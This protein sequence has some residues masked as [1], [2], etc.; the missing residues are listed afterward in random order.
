MSEE[1]RNAG[2]MSERRGTGDMGHADDM[3]HAGDMGHASDMSERR[4]TG[5][6][7]DAHDMSG[8]CG[9]A[10][11]SD[12]GDMADMGEARDTG[13]MS[14]RRDTG[15]MGHAGDMSGPCGA[16]RASDAGDMSESLPRIAISSRRSLIHIGSLDSFDITEGGKAAARCLLDYLE[17][18]GPELLRRASDIYDGIIPNENFGGEY[19]A[20]QWICRLLLAPEAARREFLSH[21]EAASWHEY[22][23]EGD[24]AKLREYIGRKYHFAELPEGDGGAARR[25]L[26]FLEDF[27]LFANPDRNRWE[28]TAKNLSRIG[29]REGDAIA[30]V[31]AGPGYFSFKF[32]DMAGG[33][34]KVYAIETN[35]M[36]LDYLHKYIGRHG[37]GNVE[38]VECGTEGIGLA[39][40]AKVDKVFMCSLYHVLYAALTEAE[41]ATYIGSIEAALAPGGRLIVVDNDLVEDGELP[42]HGP[43]I[44]KDLIV[45][46]LW[47]YGFALR[48]SFRFT[49]QRY[50]LI[51]GR[52]GEG[53]NMAGADTCGD[54]GSGEPLRGAGEAAPSAT[55][56]GG[57]LLRGAGEAAPSAT[58]DGG[59]LL[60]GA[61]E[62][63]PS[64]CAAQ[65]A[66]GGGNSTRGDT[67]AA[68]AAASAGGDPLRGDGGEPNIAGGGG[69]TIAVRSRASLVNYRIADA[70]PT[71]GFTPGGR[72]A[73]ALFLDALEAMD[74]HLIQSAL[75][76]YR[77]LI[78]RERA[79]DEYTAFEWICLCLL[80]GEG[81]R[82]EML[83]DDLA[84]MY[85]DLLAGRD[86][87]VLRKYLKTK[88]ELPGYE[89]D[90]LPDLGKI[91]E[92]IAF[93]NPNRDSWERTEEMLKFIG[94]R[95]GQSVAD[96]GCG[97]GYFTYR[98]AR[99][100]GGDRGGRSDGDGSGR[101]G[102]SRDGNGSGN[103]GNSD[104]N[105]SG[106]G[107]VYATE[108]NREA[109]SYVEDIRERFSLPIRPI[110][111]RLDD[112]CLPEACAD[113]VFMCSMYHAVYIASIE[114]VKDAFV[115]SVKKALRP[116]GRLI[117]VDND[118][119]RPGVVPYYG[120]AI[121]RGLV[122]AQ[123]EHYGFA[124][125]DSR[126][127]VPQRYVLAFKAH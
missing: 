52:A 127:F 81:R 51:F 117:V 92:Y 22:L 98:F 25:N 42:Y 44:A 82:A 74:A 109:L 110:V 112:A 94:L 116:G 45:A 122:V 90:P 53:G 123:L 37:I 118:I 73:A 97:S 56:D 43:Y 100:V 83:A 60:R 14:E 4:D 93:N 54:S 55:G 78:P 95:R 107:V 20:L 72:K 102:N 19:T 15:D 40:G 26:R 39:P 29:I 96:I 36:H 75:D 87:E 68:P 17:G 106:D 61:G 124:L 99:A 33:S 13:D 70:A 24:Y 27:I 114:F 32:A 115:A 89:S 64:A 79:G 2:D 46:Q 9:T 18:G 119:A 21:P 126:Q 85:F 86:F 104:G 12:A 84:R 6:K 63:A 16:A 8:A 91:S 23:A 65:G 120:S 69:R 67:G 34:G 113:A 58:G 77:E 50:A 7:R 31:G 111:S 10:R 57:D 76:A 88:Y 108:I 121:D 47:H 28:N 80:A 103:A 11:A 62:A 38:A 35:P 30:D 101:N 49:A 71:A 105:D 3:G 125:E 48:D 1:K 5:E 66:T 41:R 59:N